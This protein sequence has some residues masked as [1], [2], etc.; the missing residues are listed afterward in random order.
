MK[1]IIIGAGW[2]G[3]H[4]ASILEKKNIEVLLVEKEKDIF[5]G[6]SGFNSNRLHLGFHYP[7]ANLTRKQCKYSFKKFILKYPSLV[8]KIKDNFIGIHKNSKVSFFDYQKIMKQS[9]LKFKV[10]KK[11]FNINNVK[12]FIK[13]DEMLI[14]CDVSI[15]YFKKKLSKIK[16][17]FNFKVVKIKNFKNYIKVNGIKDKFDWAIDCSGCSIKKMNNFN[18]LYEP[19][20]TLV[21]KSKKKSLAIMIMDGK[22]WSIYPIKKDL[23][24]LGSVIHSRLLNGFKDKLKAEQVIKKFKKTDVSSII[25]KFEDQVLS[26]FPK[27]KSFFKYHSFY[28]S[29]ATINN[30]TNDDRPFK[31]Y[32]KKRIISVL[33]GKIDTVIEAGEKVEKTLKV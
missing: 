3:C 12:G 21:Y 10:N 22:F 15:D 31:I 7:R 1:V 14:K 9:D 30:S 13:C 11:I 26:D 8:D 23:Y 18:V 19:R 4:I 27:F 29:L 24:S 20:I 16:K 33:G 28:T 25:Q 6:Q 2:Y 17:K 32:K 5:L